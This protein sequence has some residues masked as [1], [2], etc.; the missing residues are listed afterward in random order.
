MRSIPWKLIATLMLSALVHLAPELQ[1]Q[2]PPY[3]IILI[4]GLNASHT[5]WTEAGGVAQQLQSYGWKNGG[6]IHV[7]LDY[8]R[9]HLSP[10]DAKET[11][12]HLFTTNV[13][14]GDFYLI[15]FDVD[16]T[17]T[18]VARE[19]DNLTT[20]FT[21]MNAFETEVFPTLLEPFR[22]GDI[23]RIDDEY[24]RVESVGSDR[25]VVLRGLYNSALRSHG[26]GSL[27]FILSNQS[28][29]AAIAK[30]GWGLKLAIDAIKAA[31]RKGKVVLV[32]HSMG[33]LAARYYAQNFSAGDVAKIVTIG[34][35]NLGAIK[36][37]IYFDEV[38]QL[39]VKSIDAR[40]E[41]VRDLAYWYDFE[42]TRDL[43]VPG[44]PDTRDNGIFLF[45]GNENEVPAGQF[46]NRDLNANGTEGDAIRGLNQGPLPND[47]EYFFLVGKARDETAVAAKDKHARRLA[48]DA[49]NDGVVLVSRQW[50]DLSN[51]YYRGG[52]L[53][54][55]TDPPIAAW[56]SESFTKIPLTKP[57]T[58]ETHEVAEVIKALDEPDTYPHAYEIV[59]GTVQHFISAPQPRG[60]IRDRDWFVIN[61]ASAGEGDITLRDFPLFTASG[62]ARMWLYSGGDPTTAIDSVKSQAG[63]DY[64]LWRRNFTQAGRYYL[65]IETLATEDS[66]QTP[67]SLSVRSLGAAAQL[68]LSA[69][70]AAIP[71][72][73]SATTQLSARIL[74]SDGNPLTSAT[75]P[76]TFT[77]TSGAASATLVGANPVNAVNGV[78]TITL[79]STTTPGLVTIQASSPGLAPGT[80]TVSVYSNPTLVSG[81]ITTNTTWTLANNPYQVTGDIE[82]RPGITLTIEP[83]VTVMFNS[84]ADMRIYGTLLANGSAS[85]HIT[86]TASAANPYVGA[87]GGLV[88]NQPQGAL[89][90]SL[91][92]CDFSYGGQVSLNTNYDVLEISG[93]AEP[94]ITACTIRDCRRNGVKIISG[95]YDNN[96]TLTVTDLPLIVDEL[97]VSRSAV[98]TI[99]PGA[100]LKL[101]EGANIRVEGGLRAN[102]T[103]AQRIVFTSIRDDAL[104]GDT[105]GNGAGAASVGDWGGIEFFDSVDD[106]NCAMQYCDIKFAGRVAFGDL[107]VPIRLDA[108]A[109]PTFKSLRFSACR[110]N[111]IDVVAGTYTTNIRFD[112]TAVPYLIRGDLKV[113]KPA[114]LT[115]AAGTLFKMANGSD[116][117]I[118][119][120]IVCQGVAGNPVRFTSIN[121][122]SR[123]GDTGNDGATA[124]SA[125]EW[126]GVSIESDAKGSSM[127]FTEFHFGGASGFNETGSPLL[128]DMRAE[129]TF[130][131]LVFSNCTTNGITIFATTYDR[132]ARLRYPGQTPYVQLGD[133]SVAT[134]AKLTIDPG[135]V[136]KLAEGCD[137]YIN[138]GLLAEGTA[139]AP[140]IFTSLADDSLLGDSNNNGSSQGV[141]SRWGGILFSNS[142]TTKDCRLRHCQFRHGGAGGLRNLGWTMQVSA[143]VNPVFENLRF[144]Q[145]TSNG[146]RVVDGAY[147]ANIV[148][149]QTAVPYLLAGDYGIE[150]S[151]GLTIAPGTLFKCYGETDIF[152]KG[153][154]TAVGTPTAPIVF[155]SFRDDRLAGDSNNDGVSNGV[156]GDWGGIVFQSESIPGASEVAHC[157]FWYGA[158]GGFRSSNAVLRFE[159]TSQK[160][161]HVKMRQVRWHGIYANGNA[162]PDLGGGAY[163]SPGQNAFLDFNIAADRYAVFNDGGATIFARNNTWDGSTVAAIAQE[164]YDKSDNA[165]KGEVIF[166]PFNPAGDNEA[167]QVSVLFPNGGETL[168]AGS[169]VTLRWYARDNFGVTQVAVSLSRDGG[170]TFQPLTSF[171]GRLE[172]YVW[173]VAGPFSS[174]CLLKVTARDAAGNERF[175]DSDDFFAIADSGS[176]VNYPPS[177][178]LPLRPLAGEEMRGSDLLIWQA[179]VDPNPFDRLVY[180]LEIDNSADFLSPELVEDNIDSSRTTGMAESAKSGLIRAG[181]NVLAVQLDRLA[182]FANLQDDVIYHWRV[183]ARDLQNAVSAFSSGTARFFM[184]KTNTAPQAVAT[185]FT[186]AG[187]LEVRTARPT[188]SWQAADDPDPSDGAEVLRYR[189]QADDD[190]EFTNDAEIAV[191]TNAG[192]TFHLPAQDLRENARYSWRVQ[193]SDDEGASSPWSGVQTFWVNALREPPAAFAIV[194]PGADYLS[195]SD[196]VMFVWQASADPDPFDS[197]RY[198][199]EWSLERTFSNVYRTAI[200]APATQLRFMRP[201]GAGEIFWRLKAVDPDSLATYAGPTG[202]EPR[203]LRW[204][205]TAVAGSLSIPAQFSLD[206]NYPN[207]FNPETTIAFGLARPGRVLLQ[208]YNLLGQK[209]RTLI[210]KDM[211]AGYASIKWDGKDD[212]AQ[213]VPT[214]I[215]VYRI[216]AGDFSATRK[217]VLMQ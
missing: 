70:S 23:I 140:I 211:P 19:G 51:G 18:R 87:W 204:Q 201:A 179:S 8:Y 188:F 21:V 99:A 194:A 55:M 103:P 157:E 16:A 158:G 44:V 79:R 86:F 40:S 155:T 98:M 184:N 34:T 49:P 11:D 92:Y 15:N 142:A 54:E 212:R 181:Q 127:S 113:D 112:Q 47:F 114:V 12:V 48:V 31:T 59:P 186:P 36:E 78:A 130:A 145:N 27:I 133:L 193:A 121:D 46:I 89:R 97:Y 209:V 187:D 146:I 202:Q 185:G 33:G 134:G 215:Y 171:T 63:Q 68:A 72:N 116:L 162:S 42:H 105:D 217:L 170:Q 117:R 126:G 119:G 95:R 64:L 166:Q 83:G 175:D 76:V 110:F 73:N 111:A 199:L 115:I 32:G 106:A 35:P 26:E 84:S 132:D 29:Q 24:M 143:L 58:W 108:R 60:G 165:S 205:G 190:G 124:G 207:P 85:Q 14:A 53:W 178:P 67:V 152:I 196:T 82:V 183:R 13:P 80:T 213:I 61:L 69:S 4:H 161:H 129:V 20:L 169:A 200:S 197:L 10:A 107:E 25:L 173:T 167:P 9:N 172:E 195:P 101:T 102:G 62:A 174:R 93:Y 189:L 144:S 156:A 45:G 100:H 153:R 177:T 90:S 164:I 81:A 206:Q 160:I 43:A 141:A 139:A 148:L 182:G 131:N 30:Q 136:I 5:I 151:A 135:C 137:L 96:F 123:G 125:G 138:G 176:G 57:D 38:V 88:I 28:N 41:A 65:R 214:G 1:A 75:N 39:L 2:Q 50:L 56:H 191:Q 74:D 208:I 216:Q 210:D 52:Y 22:A 147:S 6:V 3:P 118:N 128:L 122:D 192:V 149:D 203:R 91:S 163:S 104:D 168:L 7:T 71:A 17:N 180:R 77:L 37:D 66:W 154:L 159:N 150:A 198:V 120:G 94:Q 109:N